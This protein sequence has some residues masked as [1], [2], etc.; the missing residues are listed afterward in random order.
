MLLDRAHALSGKIE[1]H[2][3]LTA[4]AREA[5][6][7]RTRANQLEQAAASLAEM[8]R[9]IAN[10]R[11][12]GLSVDF[13]VR[14]GNEPLEKIKLLRAAVHE[15]PGAIQT[16]TFNLK[17]ALIDRVAGMVEAGCTAA[18]AGWERYVLD[19]ANFGAIEVLDALAR[20]P[21]FAAS[22]AKIRRIRTEVG[23]LAR[24]TPIDPGAAIAT[25]NAKL[26]EHDAIWAHVSADGIPAG[27][28]KFL[29]AAAQSGAQIT[30]FDGEVRAWF[31]QRELLSTFCIRLR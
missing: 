9:S 4:H 7:F 28:V 27:V 10:L 14:E 8:R 13:S 11:A 23:D 17:H 29:R 1:A 16:P 31:E 20:V 22:I 21:Q 6:V 26:D 30:D 19:R 5:G 3:K 25:L 12:A 24:K 18:A 2:T 15:D